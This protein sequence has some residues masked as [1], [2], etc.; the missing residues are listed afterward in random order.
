MT[1]SSLSS[2]SFNCTKTQTIGGKSVT[3]RV[4][5]A[6]GGITPAT[7]PTY[8]NVV[9]ATDLQVRKEVEAT[10]QP[11]TITFKYELTVDSVKEID[12]TTLVDPGALLARATYGPPPA[13]G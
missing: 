12:L 1:S 9:S 7:V 3:W 8:T 2:L 10:V 4:S 6:A 11:I 13:A 5:V